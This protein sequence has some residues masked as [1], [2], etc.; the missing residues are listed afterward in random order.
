M[1]IFLCTLIF[2]GQDALGIDWGTR[3]GIGALVILFI[4][5]YILVRKSE[6]ALK[7]TAKP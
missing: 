5:G 7:E 3:V 2:K 1:I 4:V 6:K